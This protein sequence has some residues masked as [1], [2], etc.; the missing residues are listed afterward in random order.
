[1]CNMYMSTT[2]LLLMSEARNPSVKM[3]SKTNNNEK[4]KI[5][6]EQQKAI[7]REPFR[8]M[9]IDDASCLDTIEGREICGKCYKSRKFFCYSCC[10]PVI[11]EK[12][13]PRIKLPIKIDIIKHA[14][15]IDGKSTAIHAAIIAPEDVK[16]YIYP[17]FPEILKTDRAVLIFPSQTAMNV[18][19]LFVKTAN[20]NNGIINERINNEFPITRA[21]FID[22][23]WHQT[24]SIYKDERLRDLPCVILK[25][26][27][28]Q[29][30]RHQKKSPRWYLAT[31]E[32][33]H[34]FLFELHACALGKIENYAT[35]EQG[36]LKKEVKSV[37]KEADLLQQYNGQ[38]DNLLYFFKYMYDKI[39]LIYDHDQLCAYKRPLI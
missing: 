33:I 2:A 25:S 6:E 32:A 38:Y 20:K 23:T 9:R 26:R 10:I 15:E 29:F 8:H 36:L 11:D 31:V 17:K 34:Q 18:E 37:I 39:H 3:C 24:K 13:I 35:L 30:W 22:S 21:V 1:M 12:Y 14:R 4:L 16:I 28:S 5:L 27:I 7:D 19:D